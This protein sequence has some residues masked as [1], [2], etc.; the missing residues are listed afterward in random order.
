MGGAVDSSAESRRPLSVDVEGVG[1]VDEALLC[2][3]AVAVTHESPVRGGGDLPPSL[4][5]RKPVNEWKRLDRRITARSPYYG[6]YHRTTVPTTVLRY[7]PP[8]YGTYHRTT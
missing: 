8:Y 6:T 4:G 5:Y 7:L 2:R 1:G 3:L